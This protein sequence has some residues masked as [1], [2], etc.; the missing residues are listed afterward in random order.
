MTFSD[1]IIEITAPIYLLRF[2]LPDGSAPYFFEKWDLNSKSV[3][4]SSHGIYGLNLDKSMYTKGIFAEGLANKENVLILLES[5]TEFIVLDST[6]PVLTASQ[7]LNISRIVPMIGVSSEKALHILAPI[8][9]LSVH[10]I[11]VTKANIIGVSRGGE[12]QEMIGVARLNNIF[13]GRDMD[14]GL[15]G[16][17]EFP[18]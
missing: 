2:C 8:T 1:E 15:T 14:A 7:M 5:S 13:K 18:L 3:I 6:R 16:S 9:N 4:D 17:T 10:E 12:F 11:A